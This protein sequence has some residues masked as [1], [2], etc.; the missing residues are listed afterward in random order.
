MYRLGIDTVMNRPRIT[1]ET[2]PRTQPP[3]LA[4]SRSETFSDFGGS[5]GLV[6]ACWLCLVVPGCG[7]EIRV[8]R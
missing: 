7:E 8:S 4:L 3:L 2:D 6:W 1:T 5:L